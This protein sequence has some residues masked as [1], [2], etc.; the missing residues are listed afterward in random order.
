MT[1]GDYGHFTGEITSL[2][3][4][5]LEFCICEL[6]FNSEVCERKQTILG[7]DNPYMMMTMRDFI[8]RY[9]TLKA[10]IP[11]YSKLEA[12]M[13]IYATYFNQLSQ[14]FEPF[15]EPWSINLEIS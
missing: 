8:Q 13:K 4:P 7:S 1:D 14:S 15:L 10:Y 12:N 11:P 3:V 9:A 5:L 6:K 2:P